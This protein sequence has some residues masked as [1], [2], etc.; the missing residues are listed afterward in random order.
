MAFDLFS[1]DDRT[2]H[3]SVYSAV[4]QTT[5]KS[6]YGGT[7]EGATD[8]ELENARKAYGRTDGLTVISGAQFLQRFERLLFLPSELTLGVEHSYDH[9]D[10]V[11]IGYD[12]RT[13]QKVHI[14][15]GVI[16]NE[17]KARKWSFLL[18]GRFD[19]HNMVDHV[20]FSPRIN[21][22]YNP[23]EQINLRLNYA[24]GFR[25]PQ[26]FD[27][28]LHIALVGG[29]RVVTQLAPD[30][31]EERSN[32]LSASIDL[33]RSFGSVE[34][35]L[36]V[37]GFYTALD[38]IFAT[39]YLPEPNEKGETVLERYNG[40]GA[41]VAGV[42]V[43]AKA[44]FSRWF[45]LQ[46]GITWQRSRY[47][48]VQH[49][50]DDAPDERRMFRSPDW[51]GY[52][53]ANF[54]PVRRFDISLSGTYTGEMLVQHAAG[55]G[56]PV[57]VAVT[58]PDFFALNVKLAYE[59]TILRTLTLQLNAGVQNLFDSYQS[60]FDQGWER[61]SGYVYGPSLPRS[62]FVRAKIRF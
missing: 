49:W 19:H 41:T 6:Y 1:R 31:R 15:S 10:D 30:L 33:Y 35:N 60:D 34:T 62:W 59:F 37:E 29:E 61:D 18:G 28:D 46:A 9:I 36:L 48:H 5:R 40:G 20:I 2:R 45:D 24:G 54:V 14:L 55:S 21:L 16:Q 58:T 11:T 53:T 43:E 38:H 23:T 39:R 57:D 52:L 42:N 50:S 13:N 56:T 47:E 44:A 26:T 8:E 51:Y 7:G 12:M 27:E 22:R 17:W 32:S 25:A 4:Q 3:L